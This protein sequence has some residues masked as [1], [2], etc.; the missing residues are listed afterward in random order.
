MGRQGEWGKDR[1]FEYFPLSPSPLI[2]T[3]WGPRVPLVTLSHSPPLPSPQPLASSPYKSIN[4]HICYKLLLV[5]AA[6]IVCDLFP[7]QMRRCI[8][9]AGCLEKKIIVSQH[10]LTQKG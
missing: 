3:S 2:P 9:T 10:S 5:V 8:T 4:H 6:C 7:A 1:G